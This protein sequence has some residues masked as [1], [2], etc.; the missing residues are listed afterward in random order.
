[1]R[2]VKMKV[3]LWEMQWVMLGDADGVGVADGAAVDDA[4]GD[5]VVLADGAAVRTAVGETVG[6]PVVARGR[7]RCCWG[8]RGHCSG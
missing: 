6:A 4:D 2:L 3:V 5:S 8:R 1:V 7:R